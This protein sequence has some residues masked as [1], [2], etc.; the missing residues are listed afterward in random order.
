MARACRT[1][2]STRSLAPYQRRTGSKRWIRSSASRPRRSNAPIASWPC[3]GHLGA[4]RRRARLGGRSRRRRRR[5]R[6]PPR[7]GSARRRAHPSGSLR[8]WKF[9]ASF[10]IGKILIYCQEP[11]TVRA[12]WTRR[13]SVSATAGW[14]V[15]A[16]PSSVRHG[17]NCARPWSSRCVE[18]T[19]RPR[20]TGAQRARA[21]PRPVRRDLARATDI[22]PPSMNRVLASLRARR[23]GRAQPAPDARRIRK[24]SSPRPGQGPAR[25]RHPGG[26]GAREDDRGPAHRRQDPGVRGL[27]RW[28]RAAHGGHH[29]GQS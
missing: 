1:D 17:G 3:R 6:P 4:Q 20:S 7:R 18:T 16:D 22:S 23:P 9:S 2:S 10:H 29:E 19:S 27:A 21:R 25:R 13:S 15:A 14:R 28:S 12:P 24:C 26:R 8:W 11:D 5:R